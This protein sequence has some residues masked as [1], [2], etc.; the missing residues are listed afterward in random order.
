MLMV[1]ET[2]SAATFANNAGDSEK[3]KQSVI[4]VIAVTL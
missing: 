1:E 4:A 3:R 2:P